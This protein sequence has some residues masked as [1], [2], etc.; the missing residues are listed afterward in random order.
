M[1]FNPLSAILKEHKLEGH[2]Y[3]VWKQNLDIVL[4]AEEYKYVLTTE[5]P[6]EPAANASA[7]VKETYRKW[8]KANEMAKCC[9]LASMSTVLQHQHQGMNTATEIMN[10]LNN[11]FGTQNRAAK[12]LAFRS[13]MTK[14]MKEGTSVRDHVLEMMSHLNQIEILGGIID[15]ESQVT[16]ILQSLPSSY[17]QFKLN[18]EM[19]K[20]AYTLAE[21]L[22]ELQP[23]EDLMVQTKAAMMSSR[24]SSSGS[25][26]GKGKKKA[27]NVVAPK[28]AKGKK[29]RVNTNKKQ[30]GKCFKCGEKGH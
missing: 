19:N 10:N 30:S 8:C 1:S 13:I 29:K 14:V 15:P 11:H 7:T 27:Q 18:F 6:P 4:T 22:T 28:I 2:N 9:M 12:S 17:Q 20:R 23:A 5:C 25:K 16:I 24:S 3:I 26:P 21:L